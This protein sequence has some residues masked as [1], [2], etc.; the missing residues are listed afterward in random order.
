MSWKAKLG[1]AALNHSFDHHFRR[2]SYFIERGH[3]LLSFFLAVGK[4]V[5]LEELSLAMMQE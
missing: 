5:M 3:V 1:I 2:P 4:A